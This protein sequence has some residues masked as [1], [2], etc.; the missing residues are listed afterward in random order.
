MHSTQELYHWTTLQPCTE[1]LSGRISEWYLWPIAIY[2]PVSAGDSPLRR[3]WKNHFYMCTK[4]TLKIL[5]TFRKNISYCIFIA[6]TSFCEGHVS[7]PVGGI[8]QTQSLIQSFS[9]DE[10]NSNVFTS[11]RIMLTH[12]PLIWTGWELGLVRE[13]CWV[14]I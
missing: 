9:R 7:W 2:L 11:T 5:L 1:P 8:F 3:T 12:L 6:F 4:D 13:W 10:V 14:C